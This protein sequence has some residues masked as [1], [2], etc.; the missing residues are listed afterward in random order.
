MNTSDFKTARRLN[1]LNRLLQVVLSITLVIGLN[2]LASQRGGWVRHPL[3]FVSQPTLSLETNK[4]LEGV[5]RR[6]PVKT[7]PDQPWV[8]IY[9]VL[10]A[11]AVEKNEQDAAALTT[12]AARAL[13]DDFVYTASKLRPRGWLEVVQ[14][15][16][17]R[18]ASVYAGL[19]ERHPA[20]N[21]S[22]AFVIECRQTSRA[23]LISLADLRT[24]TSYFRGED[25]IMSAILHV[26]DENPR[27]IYYTVGHDEMSP[28]DAKPDGL[29]TLKIRLQSRNIA[30]RP[31]NLARVNAVPTDANLVLLA[32][33][34]RPFPREEQEKLVAY[35]RRSAKRPRMLALFDAGTTP[36]LEELLD[37]W[38]ILADNARVWDPNS[39]D[40]NGLAIVR[41]IAPDHELTRILIAADGSNT[42]AGSLAYRL[43]RPVRRDPAAPPDETLRVT[44]LLAS[45]D[46]KGSAWGE[47]DYKNEPFRFDPLRGDLEAPVSMAAVAER[48]VGRDLGLNSTAGGRLL[49]L[50]SGDF[51]SNRLISAA[52]NE[53]FILNSI[54]W[55]L[56]LDDMLNIPPRPLRQFKLSEVRSS[57]LE[58]LTWRLALIPIIVLLFGGI[59]TLWRKHT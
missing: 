39:T 50:G 47:R 29:A 1:A 51:A 36:R 2:V 4:L 56:D 6:A 44:E 57:D 40:A 17:F 58:R 7:S 21:Q 23:R 25:V 3:P 31:L 52:R 32:A 13:R 38:G 5:A 54:N 43:A 10:N 55:L 37:E 48:R 30:L 35:M 18:R 12:D 14:T 42:A 24:N 46:D 20:L 34:K 8:I 15:D 26:T 9:D 53:F 49:V 28:D 59:V 41:R 19:K 22:H 11:A 45:S 33:P 27:N 16:A